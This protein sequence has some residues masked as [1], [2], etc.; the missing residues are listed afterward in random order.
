M[1]QTLAKQVAKA[2]SVVV[3]ATT[4]TTTALTLTAPPAKAAISP[5]ICA[6]ICLASLEGGPLAYALCLA[7][8]TAFTVAPDA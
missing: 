7:A 1:K 5:A 6:Y 3:L 4:L 8:C 2:M